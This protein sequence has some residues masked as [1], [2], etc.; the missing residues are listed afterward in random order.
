MSISIKCN[1]SL[2][3]KLRALIKNNTKFYMKSGTLVNGVGEGT[4]SFEVEN[5]PISSDF[6]DKETSIMIVPLEIDNKVINSERVQ[7]D[8]HNSRISNIF[9]SGENIDEVD[10]SILNKIGAIKVPNNKIERASAIKP[11]QQIEEETPDVFKVTQKPEAKK[12]ITELNQLLKA[13]EL[14]QN[15]KPSKSEDD[16]NKIQNPRLRAVA[17]EEK[18]RAEAIDY[19]AFIVNISCATL[20]IND[21]GINLPLNTPYNLN[22]LSAK[23][24]ANSRE[25]G[26]ML[27]SN[28]IKFIRPDEVQLYMDKVI[29]EQD[30]YGLEV[31]DNHSQAEAAIERGVESK[32]HMYTKKAQETQLSLEDL[33]GPTE[34]ERI[35]RSLSPRGSQSMQLEQYDEQEIQQEDEVIR[36][37]HK[38]SN[39][40]LKQ[41]DITSDS[42]ENSKGIKSIRR[43]GISFS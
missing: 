42:S 6:F 14:A 3:K 29:N 27:R 2:S 15:K 37:S 19:P 9:S 38:I 8:S 1:I 41:K 4:I 18:E 5:A 16:I 28:M 39:P 30:K 36:T 34:E 12:Y 24:I 26:A 22:N 40:R 23:K 11:K 17:M 10:N 33:E 35:L 7:E 43:S 25:L 31:Y 21:L 20:T 32:S 13:V